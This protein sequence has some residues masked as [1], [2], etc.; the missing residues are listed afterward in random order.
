MVSCYCQQI[1]LMISE[2]DHLLICLLF[3]PHST[4]RN[5]LVF[6]R[7]ILFVVVVVADVV[8]IHLQEFLVLP[9]F[10]ICQL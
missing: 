4:S 3:I 2:A 1:P 5:M 9:R 10:I 8:F 6:F 7:G